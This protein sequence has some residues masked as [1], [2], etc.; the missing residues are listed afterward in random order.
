MKQFGLNGIYSNDCTRGLR[1]G[2]AS[3]RYDIAPNGEAKIVSFFPKPPDKPAPAN[4]RQ[5]YDY[6]YEL[7]ITVAEATPAGADKLRLVTVGPDGRKQETVL[8]RVGD[9]VRPWRAAIAGKTVIEDGRT[10]SGGR[11]VPFARRCSPAEVLTGKWMQLTP[12]GATIAQFSSTAMAF[13]TMDRAGKLTETKSW[14]ATYR[15]LNDGSFSVDLRG[16][17]RVIVVMADPDGL[18]LDFPRQPARRMTRAP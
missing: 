1:Q 3:I 15:D 18:I 12:D 10:A 4:T 16:G 14:P 9:Q 5:I 13:G 6:A 17:E 11:D 2:G 7:I 8:Q